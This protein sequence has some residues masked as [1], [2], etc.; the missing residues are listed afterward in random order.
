MATITEQFD[1]EIKGIFSFFDRININ[2]YLFPLIIEQTRAGVLSQMGILMK[3]F[4]NVFKAETK[5]LKEH[6]EAMAKANNREIIYLSAT[7]KKKEDIAKAELKKRPIESGLICILKTQ[8][9]CKTAKVV[10]SDEGLLKIKTVNTK[11]L[12]YYLYFQDK[13][14]GFMFVKI[15]TWFPFNIQVYINGREMMKSVFDRNGIKYQCY[16]NSFTDISDVEKAQELAD[17]FDHRKLARHLDGIV[18]G[19]NPFLEKFTEKFGQ[20]YSW[21][22]N[23]CEYATDVM[24]KERKFLEDINPSLVDRAFNSLTCTD[25]FTFMGRKLDPRFQGEAVSDYKRRPIGCR[26]KF[27]LKSNSVKMYD[28][29]SV[30]RI[31]T[32][33]N[34]PHEFKIYAPVHHRDGSQSMQWKPMGKSISNLYRYAEVSKSCNNRFLDALVNVIPVESTLKKIDNICSRKKVDGKSVKGFNV[35]DPD[36]VRTMETISQGNFLL[37]GFRN[38]D[39]AHLVYPEIKCKKKRSAKTTRLLKRLRLFGLIRK[40]PKVRR[41]QVTSNGRQI[42]GTL[43]ELRRRHFPQLFAEF[44]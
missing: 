23:Q 14:Y 44:V 4:K 38:K 43:I 41:Y 17:K 20:G 18:K 27:K 32:T 34:D 35:W 42:M 5:A 8:E 26:V 30:L 11:C 24:F 10:G 13:E 25:V 15:Q 3:D 12:H 22:V 36:F 21:Y 1:E 40:V 2:A 39:I 37:N 6:L 31:E 19:I 7:T 16:D 29:Y 33:I 9:L 28:K